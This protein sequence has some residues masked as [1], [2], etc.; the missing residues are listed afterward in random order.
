MGLKNVWISTLSDGL[1]RGDQVVGIESHRTPELTGKVSRW[2]L[3]VTLAVP[4]G[5][6]N[7]DGWDVAE[8]HRTLAQSD[9]EPRSAPSEL[10]RTLHR[11]GEDDEAGVLRAVTRDGS[12]RLEFTPFDNDRDRD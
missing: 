1:I 12:L 5:S 3:D 2:L 9:T 4:A 6:G 11:L 8:L 10:A 7:A